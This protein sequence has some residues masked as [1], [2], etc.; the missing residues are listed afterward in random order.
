MQIFLCNLFAYRAKDSYQSLPLCVWCSLDW[1]IVTSLQ[2]DWCH[3]HCLPRFQ[4]QQ[5]FIFQKQQCVSQ[6]LDRVHRK[7]VRHG[8]QPPMYYLYDL[9]FS[10]QPMWVH[11]CLRSH[12]FG[13]L[14]IGTWRRVFVFSSCNWVHICPVC[15]HSTW[16]SVLVDQYP[17]CKCHYFGQHFSCLFL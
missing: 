6:F 2:T 13:V 8:R 17:R 5:F 9:K 10:S 15:T 1:W 14:F 3:C 12:H 11:S 16:F 4:P 7:L